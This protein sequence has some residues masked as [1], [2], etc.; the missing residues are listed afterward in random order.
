MHN[1]IVQNYI[2]IKYVFLLYEH[3]ITKS[4]VY[5][6]GSTNWKMSKLN[7]SYNYDINY[8]KMKHYTDLGISYFDTLIKHQETALLIF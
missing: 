4:F 8:R 6:F 3:H 7:P 5:D 2:I 1:L